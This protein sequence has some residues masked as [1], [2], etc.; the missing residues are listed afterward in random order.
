MAQNKRSKGPA[1]KKTLLRRLGLL[2]VLFLVAGSISYP[3]G[4]NWI[5][6]RFNQVTTLKVDHVNKPVVLGLDLQG[7]T[8]LE[9]E[10]DLSKIGMNE[11]A[12]A[13]DG[14][15]DVIERRVNA[16]GV[17]EPLVQT[18]QSGNQWRLTIELAGVRD[19]KQAIQMI[20]ETPTLDFRVQN[21]DAD[22]PPT[23]AEYK[24]VADENARRKEK[25]QAVLDQIKKGDSLERIARETSEDTASA[26]NG[27]DLGWI[28]NQNDYAKI[29][30]VLSD[31]QPGLYPQVIDNGINFFIVDLLEKK[32][33]GQEIQASHILV[34]WSGSE[35]SSSTSTKDQALVKIKDIQSKVTAANFEDMA[36]KYSEEP[37]ADK[38]AGDLGWFRKGMMV[39]AF[40]DA[41]FKLKNGEVSGIVETP[42]GYHIIKVTGIRDAFDE[43][44]RAVVYHQQKISDVVN[45]EP[46]K[47][48]D[49][50]GKQVKRATLDFDQ[51]TGSSQVLISFNDEGAKLFDQL[52]K[53]N[54]G[55]PIAIYLDGKPISIPTVQ[56]EIPNG[57]A[58]ISGNFTVD[59]AKL[60]AQ[61]LQAGALPVPINL[62]AQQSVGPTLGSQ[63]VQDSLKAGLIGFAL[64]FLFM[65]LYYRVP[66]LLADIALIFYVAIVIAIFKLIPVTLTLSG[67]AGFILSMGIAVDANVL[68]FE[69]LKEEYAT[70]KPSGAAIDEA[71]KRAWTSIRDGNMTTLI[72]C[73]VLYMFTSSLVKGFALTLGIGILVSMFTAITVARV[74]LKLVAGS[75]FASKIPWLLLRKRSKDQKTV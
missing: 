17:S 56:V 74:L 10:A 23:D 48:T 67:I 60:L 57:E 19:I 69:R 51:R 6:D 5:I 29:A 30:E 39:Q 18:T 47:R 8:R 43:H 52:T 3:Q 53:A 68:V 73:A 31:Q 16:M 2:V 33:A 13:M 72:S 27:G 37:G 70:G 28:L 59:E 65:L 40:E 58:V 32:P 44:V 75:A 71:F 36:K 62:I 66:G 12:S 55:K 1:S 14:V 24:Q 42:F 64:V 7:G 63:S 9:Y 45:S 35:Q 25:A 4:A 22:R 46:W 61:R 38:S 54:I 21:P 49:L 11:R 34:Q 50:T 15:R 41:A 20:G 26:Q